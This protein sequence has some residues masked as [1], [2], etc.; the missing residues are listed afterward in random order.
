[1]VMVMRM[2]RASPALQLTPLM[3]NTYHCTGTD[4]RAPPALQHR[5]RAYAGRGRTRRSPAGAPIAVLSKQRPDHSTSSVFS[6]K[7]R[8]WGI[9]R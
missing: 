9:D 8:H 1:M 6:M 5:E 7:G 2:Q 3:F 4:R